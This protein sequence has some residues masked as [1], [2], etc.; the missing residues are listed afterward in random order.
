MKYRNIFERIKYARE[1]NYK[2]SPAYNK[3]LQEERKHRQII[4]TLILDCHNFLKMKVTKMPIFKPNSSLML[5]W[6]SFF[7]VFVLFLLVAVPLELS[8]ELPESHKAV[9][10]ITN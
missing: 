10:K 9:L 2:F 5:I 6:D 3:V 4:L 1:I 7:L 8:F